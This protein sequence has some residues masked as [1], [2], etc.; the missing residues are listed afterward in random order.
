MIDHSNLRFACRKQVNLVVPSVQ[1]VEIEEAKVQ[2]L[3]GAL[4]QLELESG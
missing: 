4:T 1:V 2:R 3:L